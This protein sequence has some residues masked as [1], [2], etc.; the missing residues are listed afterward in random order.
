MQKA[1]RK[2]SK[3]AKVS[4][5]RTIEVSERTRDDLKKLKRDHG[6]KNMDEAVRWFIDPNQE[7]D[8]E[9]SGAGL[10]YSAEE[11]SGEGDGKEKVPQMLNEHYVRKNAAVV[12]YFT[13]MRRGAYRWIRK[14]L[15]GEVC[16]S[17]C[18]LSLL[19]S[20]SSFRPCHARVRDSSHLL[21]LSHSG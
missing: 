11:D 18:F 17:V 21:H 5:P 3:A 6:L 14:K 8:E 12:K 15:R 19:I 13:G 10:A 9:G 1:F 7:D 16:E 4:R 2:Q 20:R